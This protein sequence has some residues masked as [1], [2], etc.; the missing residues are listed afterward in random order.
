[1]G[2]W[3]TESS[4]RYEPDLISNS[5]A[6]YVPSCTPWEEEESHYHHLP[7]SNHHYPHHQHHIELE[8]EIASPSALS[9]LSDASIAVVDM[10]QHHQHPSLLLPVAPT[11]SE[12]PS[13]ST[14]S[15]MPAI[16]SPTMTAIT[17]S[18]TGGC[19]AFYNAQYN[20]PGRDGS[21]SQMYMSDDSTDEGV[22]SHSFTMTCP[23]SSCSYYAESLWDIW[24]HITW[25]HLSTRRNSDDH[26]YDDGEAESM[27]ERMVLGDDLC[28]N[29]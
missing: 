11:V 20:R 6:I 25:G 8:L 24:R 10:N 14:F 7:D 23:V 21:A 17:D 12:S 1:M 9:V 3:H 5:L 15:G 2:E 13:L 4:A 27:V 19:C 29:L 28:E 18:L 26:E 16:T 22:Q